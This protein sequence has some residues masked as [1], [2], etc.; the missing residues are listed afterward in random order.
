MTLGPSISME[1]FLVNL[2]RDWKRDASQILGKRGG[3]ISKG[4][5]LSPNASTPLTEEENLLTMDELYCGFEENRRQ[6]HPSGG[7]FPLLPTVFD[8]GSREISYEDTRRN[9]KVRL[10]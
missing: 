7:R 6:T 3:S 5:L 4:P 10:R 8:F 1:D 2:V 9:Y